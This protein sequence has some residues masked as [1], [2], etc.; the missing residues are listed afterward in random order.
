MSDHEHG[1][2]ELGE[3]PSATAAT[4]DL[5]IGNEAGTRKGYGPRPDATS[6]ADASSVEEFMKMRRAFEEERR[7][8]EAQKAA[9]KEECNRIEM[10]RYELEVTSSAME[11]ER[12]ALSRQRE[13]LDRPDL[14]RRYEVLTDQYV[15][16]TRSIGR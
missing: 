3:V 13:E 1:D 11:Q 9:H 2:G 16:H 12:R 15:P 8:F 6:A 14:K 7:L 10:E 4:P 5:S